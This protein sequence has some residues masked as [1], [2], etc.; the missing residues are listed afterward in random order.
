M[1]TKSKLFGWLAFLC[2]GLMC[3]SAFNPFAGAAARGSADTASNDFSDNFDGYS[4]GVIGENSAFRDVWLEKSHFGKDKMEI[5]ADPEDEN[6]KTL[7]ITSQGTGD[8]Y[9]FIAPKDYTVKNFVLTFRM[10]LVDTN[11]QNS[12]VSICC[13]KEEHSRYDTTVCDLLTLNDNT[14]KRNLIAYQPIFFNKNLKKVMKNEEGG[15]TYGIEKYQ[16]DVYAQW[17]DVEIVVQDNRYTAYLDGVSMGTG[18]HNDNLNAGYISLNVAD[19][20]VY[21][22]DFQIRNEDTYAVSLTAQKG[23]TA[24]SDRLT[25]GGSEVKLQAKADKGY[26]FAG[27][28]DETDTLVSTESKLS[29][30]P[31]S[32]VNYTAKFQPLPFGLEIETDGAGSASGAGEYI[33]D[34]Q[35]QLSATTDAGNVFV[36]WFLDGEKL[37]TDGNYAFTMPADDTVITA[38]FVA[39][40]TATYTVSAQSNNLSYGEVVGSGDFYD[41]EPVCLKAAPYAGFE[42][43]GWY[44]GDERI[45]ASERYVFTCAEDIALTAKFELLKYDVKVVNGLDGRKTVYRT[46][47]GNTVTVYPDAAPMGYMFSNWVTSVSYEKNDDG[48]ITFVMPEKAVDVQAK[49]IPLTYHVELKTDGVSGAIGGGVKSFGD[50][51]VCSVFVKEGYRLVGFNVSGAEVTLGED[52]SVSFVM[53][54]NDVT[55]QA[56]IVKDIAFPFGAVFGL[57]GGGLVIVGLIVWYTAYSLKKKG[58]NE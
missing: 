1:K 9:W 42:F 5:A 17:F 45:S 58:E 44:V 38:L 26:E 27:W 57:I 18:I 13:R 43:A 24:T 55:V 7:K 35:V 6:N 10:Y 15:I 30:L 2:G 37:S 32:D 29:V 50:K 54:A 22:D 48:S 33:T 53:P 4:V 47:A 39:D 12:W 41:G 19:N 16:P 11:T 25:S 40:G 56:V 31:E 28:Y 46:E 51:V 36:G 23:G 21:I 3:L 14:A 34:A 20:T 52:G 49:Y 8:S